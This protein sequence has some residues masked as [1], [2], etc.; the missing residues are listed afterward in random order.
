MPNDN[1]P[2]RILEQETLSDDYWQ[3]SKVTFSQR[4]R[5][6][7][8]Q[9]ETREVYHN[10]GG[11]AV[12]LYNRDKRTVLLTR[13]FRIGARLA[14]HDGFIIEVPAGMLDDADPATR[15]RAE[16]CEETGFRGHGLRKVI[17]FFPN[18]SALT[19]TVHCFLGEY[20]ERDRKGEGGGKEEE[21]ED[22][23]VLEMDIDEA[24]RQVKEGG[25]NDAK[26]VILLQFL[27]E[28]LRQS[29]GAQ[30]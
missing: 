1:D 24:F 23:E 2:I 26:T 11:A 9:E 15:V 14:G 20:E 27:R 13:Q 12:L 22:I 3:L 30:L 7:S 28:E 29:N 10:A 8:E 18:P 16:L 6:G 19:E 17:E 5:D 21:G 4:R 25:I